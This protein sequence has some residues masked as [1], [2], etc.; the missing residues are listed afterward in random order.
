MKY[1]LSTGQ[2]TDKVEYYI[3]D[4][5]K[6]Y[7]NIWPKDIPHSE[8]IGFDFILTDVKKDEL[9]NTVKSR[10]KVLVNKI[11][12]KFTRSLSI[13]I[14]SIEIIDETKIRISINVNQIKADD[15]FINIDE[16][17]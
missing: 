12:E 7:L 4:L 1:L 10:I 2:S 6:L 15:I 8:D 3:I 9:V 16:Q 14:E 13:S 11:K 17:N 5:F